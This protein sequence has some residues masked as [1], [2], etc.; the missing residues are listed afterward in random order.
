MKILPDNN[1]QAISVECQFGDQLNQSNLSLY[2][3]ECSLV[4]QFNKN[5]HNRENSIW[6]SYLNYNECENFYERPKKLKRLSQEFNSLCKSKMT[7][8]PDKPLVCL[9]KNFELIDLTTDLT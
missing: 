1:D 8:K 2:G 4:E 3:D 7:L 9:H 5:N 6:F